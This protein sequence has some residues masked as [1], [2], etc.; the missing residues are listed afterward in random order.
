[1]SLVL[2]TELCVFSLT[3]AF[4]TPL[5]E[6]EE[7]DDAILQ[8]LLDPVV[9]VSESPVTWSKDDAKD[10][11][12]VYIRGRDR[13]SDQKEFTNRTSLNHEGLRRGNVSLRLSSVRRA[14]SGTYTCYIQRL[15]TYCHTGL[16][17]VAR[18]QLIRPRGVS[19]NVTPSLD[20]PKAETPEDN[21]NETGC[22]VKYTVISIFLGVLGAVILLILGTFMTCKKIQE[23]MERKVATRT[24]NTEMQSL[25]GGHP[26]NGAGNPQEVV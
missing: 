17:V 11:V 26:T 10:M 20:V 1:M 16:K 7:G 14:D 8:C 5:I 18:G 25:S 12:H 15:D 22:D 2:L 6:A 3:L 13:A 21:E 23:K 9:D 4:S 24:T 19:L